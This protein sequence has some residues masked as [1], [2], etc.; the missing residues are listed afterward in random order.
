MGKARLDVSPGE[1]LHSRSWELGTLPPERSNRI[2]H[3][4]LIDIAVLEILFEHVYMNDRH[5]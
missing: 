5:S 1:G 4:C 3:R 2:Y